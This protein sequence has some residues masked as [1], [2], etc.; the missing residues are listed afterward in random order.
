[1]AIAISAAASANAQDKREARLLDPFRECGSIQESDARLA[2]FDEA[3][4]ALPQAQAEENRRSEQLTAE[5][6][7]MSER[8]AAEADVPVEA[9]DQVADTALSKNADGDYI[10]TLT[11]ADVFVDKTSRMVILF[12]NGQLW[13][14]TGNGNM[15]GRLRAGWVAEI[16]PSGFGGYRLRIQ[17]RNGFMGVLRVK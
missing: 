5:T 4:L 8:A 2:C 11:I 14:E 12:E 10:L 1:M 17:G 6:F 9:L 16:E 13:R 3:L 7:G 15:R